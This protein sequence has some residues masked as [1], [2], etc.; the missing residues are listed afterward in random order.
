MPLSRDGHC[1]AFPLDSDLFTPSALLSIHPLFFISPLLSLSNLP[2]SL[3]F[4]SCAS[5]LPFLSCPPDLFPFSTASLAQLLS[6]FSAFP[7]CIP[8]STPSS[9]LFISC[10]SDLPSFYSFA[11]SRSLAF[12][13]LYLSSI[14]PSS[15]LSP[16]HCHTLIKPIDLALTVCKCWITNLEQK[17]VKF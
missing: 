10:S 8:L 7:L 14:S 4:L 2:S 3:L 9:L 5:P 6:I 15:P 1:S 11:H 13:S 17:H 16:S 12:I